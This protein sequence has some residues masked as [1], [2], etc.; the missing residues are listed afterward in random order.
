MSD[1]GGGA[2]APG[3]RRVEMN[4]QEE[5]TATG[6]EDVVIQE[7]NGKVIIDGHLII[8]HQGIRYDI[9]GQRID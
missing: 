9:T 5:Q 6:M 7:G 1:F 8:I 3:R 4:V 2:P